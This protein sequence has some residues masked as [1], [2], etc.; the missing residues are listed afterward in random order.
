MCRKLFEISPTNRNVYLKIFQ[1]PNRNPLNSWANLRYFCEIRCEKHSDALCVTFTFIFT[2][3][4]FSMKDKADWYTKYCSSW[5]LFRSQNL[6]IVIIRKSMKASHFQEVADLLIR[7]SDFP[8]SSGIRNSLKCFQELC[9]ILTKFLFVIIAYAIFKI[10]KCLQAKSKLFIRVRCDTISNPDKI[11]H[12]HIQFKVVIW[13]R[14]FIEIYL[15]QTTHYLQLILNSFIYNLIIIPYWLCLVDKK[16]LN[17]VK[18][19]HFNKKKSSWRTI[20][21][22]NSTEQIHSSKVLIN[23]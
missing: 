18:V 21:L 10:S 20:L 1:Q 13:K 17:W 12:H 11:H 8:I 4:K 2:I 23:V 6:F 14:H 7:N 19:T 9:Q 15:T 22:K 5:I 16:N 3:R